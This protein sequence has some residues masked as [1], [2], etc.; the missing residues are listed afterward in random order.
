MALQMPRSVTQEGKEVQRFPCSSWCMVRQPMEV[1]LCS[2]GKTTLEH[3]KS[4]RDPP[5]V[6]ENVAETWTDCSPHPPPSTAGR[7]SKRNLK[8]S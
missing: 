6:E 8:Q 5:S 1:C 7:K 3:E 4:V 2:P